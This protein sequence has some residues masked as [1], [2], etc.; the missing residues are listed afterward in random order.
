[1]EEYILSTMSDQVN[2]IKPIIGQLNKAIE[3]Y[4]RRNRKFGGK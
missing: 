3:E 2:V 1:M 4:S